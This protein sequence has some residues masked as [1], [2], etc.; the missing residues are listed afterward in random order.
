LEQELLL[1][2]IKKKRAALEAARKTH[3]EKRQGKSKHDA[4]DSDD[5]DLG[6]YGDK[7]DLLDRLIAITLESEQTGAELTDVQL[8]GHVMTFAFAGHETS[9]NGLAW[10]VRQPLPFLSSLDNL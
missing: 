9:S 2:I 7:L 1:P 5:E 3:L 10:T 8:M 4:S 6:Y